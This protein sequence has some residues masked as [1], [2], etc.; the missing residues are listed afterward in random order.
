VRLTLQIR[1]GRASWQRWNLRSRLLH[2]VVSRLIKRQSNCRVSRKKTELSKRG[3]MEAEMGQA[4]TLIIQGTVSLS[5]SRSNQTL[6]FQC[7]SQSCRAII[8]AI[9]ESATTQVCIN[10]GCALV[11]A[12]F[13]SEFIPRIHTSL[14]LAQQSFPGFQDLVSTPSVRKVVRSI[15]PTTWGLNRRP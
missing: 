6:E 8:F 10:S 12:F 3:Y 2:L 9:N 11:N 4:G 14:L 13:V 15:R 7:P 1:S 5:N